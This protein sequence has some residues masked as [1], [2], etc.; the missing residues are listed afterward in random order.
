M[1]FLTADCA[2]ERVLLKG[3]GVALLLKMVM[4]SSLED[5]ETSSTSIFG[6][7]V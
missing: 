1:V 3:F 6:S 4:S 2:G 5:V 7:Q